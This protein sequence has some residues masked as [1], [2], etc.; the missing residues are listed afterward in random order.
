MLSA[1]S[2][3]SADREASGCSDNHRRHAGV[4]V[5]SQCQ[6]QALVPLAEERGAPGPHGGRWRWSFFLVTETNDLPVYSKCEYI[7]DWFIMMQCESLQAVNNIKAW[8]SVLCV[9]GYFASSSPYLL[10]VK[11]K[12]APRQSSLKITT[13]L[14]PQAAPSACA[15]CA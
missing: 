1:R 14:C 6:A 3:A 4:G 9:Y 11:Q 8:A 5:Q 12:T 13:C 7:I 15:A 10:N 2:R